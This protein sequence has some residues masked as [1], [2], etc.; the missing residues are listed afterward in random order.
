MNAR[1]RWQLF[2]SLGSRWPRILA[3]SCCAL[4]IAGAAT[5]LAGAQE[6]RSLPGLRLKP[7]HPTTP[8]REARQQ[9]LQRS[10]T[11]RGLR[12][13][14]QVVSDPLQ[15]DHWFFSVTSSR[16]GNQ[17]AGVM[18]GS[19]ALGGGGGLT[20]TPVQIIPVIVNTVSVGIGTDIFGITVTTTPGNRTLDPGAADPG[21]VTTS[22]TKGP[23]K[24]FKKSP[25]FKNAAFNFGGTDVG[26]VQYGDAIQRAQFWNTIDTETYHVR[27]GPLT[28]SAPLTINVPAPGGR[29]GGLA[30]DALTFGLCGP[31]AIVDVNLID[32]F[33]TGQFAALAAEGVSP[34][35]FPIFIFYNTAFSLGDP[36]DLLNC[37]AGG[38]HNAVA[39]ADPS[40]VQTYAVVDFDTSGAFGVGFMDTAIASHAIAEWMNDPL[41]TNPTPGW[42]DIGQAQAACQHNLEVGDPLSGAESPRIFMP[43]PRFTYHLQ[44]EAFFSWFF[45][46]VDGVSASI[47]ANGWFS[48]NGT[49]LTDAG[50]PCS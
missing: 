11:V 8:S 38:Y 36:T 18:V 14:T 19:P 47:G 6:Q 12:A 23:L 9:W 37:C 10:M 29:T 7:Y 30:L 21:C 35:V 46:S 15:I 13:T 1:W 2:A 44:E 20:S 45:G 26:F 32:N 16:D 5:T 33:V 39:A 24:I 27:L 40:V 49:L 17:Y 41:G 48:S 42:G 3:L 34:S 31:V 50:P 28:Q 4:L 43:V 22:P 25:L